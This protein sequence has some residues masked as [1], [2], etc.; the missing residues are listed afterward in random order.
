MVK[1]KPK[2]N[3]NKQIK[4]ESSCRSKKR[5]QLFTNQF[6]N[7]MMLNVDIEPFLG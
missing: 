4:D 2:Q 3:N 5:N 7:W 6:P 1:F